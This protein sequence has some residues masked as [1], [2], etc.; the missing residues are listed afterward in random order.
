LGIPVPANCIAYQIEDIRGG[1]EWRR[2][3]VLLNPRGQEAAFTIPQGAWKIYGDARQVGTL[4]L[5]SS[6]SRLTEAQAF[7]APRSALILGERREDVN[8]EEE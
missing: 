5:A 3:L 6:V 8:H 1:D 4:P 7:V 2:A